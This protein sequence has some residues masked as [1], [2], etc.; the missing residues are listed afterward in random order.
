MDYLSNDCR[1]NSLPAHLLSSI[2][3][4]LPKEDRIF[5]L[6]K[7]SRLWQA[8][9]KQ[10]G[11]NYFK[12]LARFFFTVEKQKYTPA[13]FECI[14]ELAKKNNLIILIQPTPHT[15]VEAQYLKVK[16]LNNLLLQDYTQISEKWSAI[17]DI[18]W[19]PE[20][21]KLSIGKGKQNEEH[22]KFSL[23]TDNLKTIYKNQ[24]L[25]YAIELSVKS[26]AVAKDNFSNKEIVKNKTFK[27]HRLIRAAFSIQLNM[28]I[29]YISY[30]NMNAIFKMDREKR[31]DHRLSLSFNCDKKG[32]ILELNKERKDL[33][34]TLKIKEYVINNH[35]IPILNWESTDAN[36]EFES[37]ALIYSSIFSLTAFRVAKK[38]NI[39]IED[40][41]N[42]FYPHEFFKKFSI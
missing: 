5:T 26:R 41:T 32:R 2:Y 16:I 20:T 7:V 1:L 38:L 11:N 24:T 30:S 6:S 29:M 23:Y 37:S 25:S 8:M 33:Q 36:Q 10:I 14:I 27:M 3:H 40:K 35:S 19:D 28:F 39:A 18:A 21:L 9:S 17:F 13:Q 34:L 12:D 22:I 4:F 15:T 31:L 42:Y